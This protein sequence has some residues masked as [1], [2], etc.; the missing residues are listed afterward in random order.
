MSQ[1]YLTLITYNF[2]RSIFL[3]NVLRLIID[4]VHLTRVD[5][6]AYKLCIFRY[7]DGM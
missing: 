6:V 4:R 3:S 5:I 2:Y 1:N 7:I